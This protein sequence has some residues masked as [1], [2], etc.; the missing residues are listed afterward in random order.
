MVASSFCGFQQTDANLSKIFLTVAV[1]QA[2]KTINKQ[3]DELIQRN[4]GPLPQ[5]THFRKDAMLP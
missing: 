1:L 4:A 3:K 5:E 2:R